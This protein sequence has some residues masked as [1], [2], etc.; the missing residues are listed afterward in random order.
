MSKRA[1]L[2]ALHY[3]YGLRWIL[4]LSISIMVVFFVPNAFLIIRH[5]TNSWCQW[6]KLTFFS[7]FI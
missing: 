2:K 4:K 1:L 6:Y 7:L 5:P 3:I